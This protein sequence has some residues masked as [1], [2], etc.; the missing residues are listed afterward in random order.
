MLISLKQFNNWFDKY[1]ISTI[2]TFSI[3]SLF[4]CTY[5]QMDTDLTHILKKIFSSEELSNRPLNL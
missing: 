5:L 2:L 1:K 4:V 3:I